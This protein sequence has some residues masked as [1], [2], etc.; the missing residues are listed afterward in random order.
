MNIYAST[1]IT[2]EI[3]QNFKP[4]RLAVKECNGVKYLC[5]T[6][7]SDFEKYTGSGIRWKRIVKKYGRK[8]V[9][10]LWV[11]D[12]FY[13][14]HH[15]Q[16]FALMYSEYNQVV[17]SD[18]WA[19]LKPE[20]GLDGGDTSK[21]ENYKKKRHLFSNAG[22]KH[23]NFG[24]QFEGEHNPNHD[25]KIYTFRHKDG[26]VEI[27]TRVALSKKHGLKSSGISGMVS[28]PGQTYLGWYIG[29]QILDRSRRRPRDHIIY[30]FVHSDGR[31]ESMTRF[32][33]CQKYKELKPAGMSKLCRG[34]TSSYLGSC[35][36]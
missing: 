9:K 18:D 36:K 17:E 34:F 31:T 25:P 28:K 29:D 13:C 1:I 6:T 12:W 10:T 23:P 2:E 24:K 3:E 26:K 4:T 14:P 16:D 20:N 8:N 5:K 35:I 30:N 15:L 7:R 19:N 32:D 21:T 27:C 22:P 11:S 33:F